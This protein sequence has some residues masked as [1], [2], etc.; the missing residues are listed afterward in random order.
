M[1]TAARDETEKGAWTRMADRWLVCA[2][3]AQKQ[4]LSAA[5]RRIGA[6]LGPAHL[7]R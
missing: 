4:Y 3:L 2:E 1:A 5:R 6:Y 7:Q